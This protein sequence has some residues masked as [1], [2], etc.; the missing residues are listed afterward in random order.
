MTE[1]QKINYLIDSYQ[2]EVKS[3]YSDAIANLTLIS[4][5]IQKGEELNRE[6]I[7]SFLELIKDDAFYS[8]IYVFNDKD[9]L[10]YGDYWDLIKKYSRFIKNE[11][12]RQQRG[13]LVVVYGSKKYV[14]SYRAITDGYSSKIIGYI[15]QIDPLRL[16]LPII[17]ES[18]YRIISYPIN[19]SQLPKHVLPYFDKIKKTIE[20]TFF[21][22]QKQTKIIRLS[23]FFAMGIYIN[24]CGSGDITSIFIIFYERSIN[25][26]AQSSIWFFVLILIAV[27]LIMIAILGNWFKKAVIHPVKV[28]SDIMKKN[29]EFPIVLRKI[30]LDY[31]GV[32]GEMIKSFNQMEESLEKYSQYLLEY[33]IAS[34]NIEN[35]VFWLDEDFKII[36]FNNSFKKIIEVSDNLN[37]KFLL[38]FIK[39][40]KEDIKK[41]KN[42]SLSL[43][44]YEYHIENKIKHLNINFR[45]VKEKDRNIIVGG[46]TDITQITQEKVAREKLELELIKTNKLA[47]IGRRVEGIVHNLNS[48]LNS[49]I[50][51]AQ[52][53]KKEIGKNEDLE[54]ILKS[55]KLIAH[56]IKTLQQKIKND[57]MSMYHPLDINKLLKDELEL[58]KNNLFFKHH[59]KTI[60]D[61]E[62]KL[63]SLNAVYGDVSMCVTN[64]I[65]NALE[66][67]ENSEKKILKVS[68]KLID[69]KY[70]QIK[71]SD[72]GC[73]I[74]KEEL[75]NIFEP[76]YTTKSY[77]KG[78]GYGLGLAISKYIVEKYKGEIMVK[79][80]IGKGS[81][82]TII[83]P[84][85]K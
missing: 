43:K 13:Y 47:E 65:N 35:G 6:N 7:V 11:I 68:T 72:T 76:Y 55:G 25:S 46:M 58:F 62:K 63:P 8:N 75:S 30:N 73:G 85:N 37:G 52:L 82:F 15:I 83:F 2:N 19:K 29:S 44:N 51:Y 79:S 33:K 67:M 49:I 41:I 53:M 24:H 81:E 22:E 80:E 32:L 21:K 66:S 4:D 26:F 84:L 16:T 70:I 69:D 39:L 42:G 1:N 45:L 59:V 77:P 27:S 20:K 36:M 34:E 64:I 3:I 57:N 12:K 28:V 48:P 23:Y 71:I 38:D 31:G 18:E 10:I 50:G 54:K 40:S 74:P 56:Y 14:F 61:F 9:E 60:T 78:S 5:F 17:A